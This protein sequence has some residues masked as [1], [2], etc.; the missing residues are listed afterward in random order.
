MCTVKKK[1]RSDSEPN[2][3][4]ELHFVVFDGCCANYH[5]GR[6]IFAFCSVDVVKNTTVEW[7]FLLL[8]RVTQSR[9]LFYKSLW[10]MNLRRSIMVW[11]VFEPRSFVF[12][13]QAS[14]FHRHCRQKTIKSVSCTPLSTK[15]FFF[16]YRCGW[17][18]STLNY[19]HNYICM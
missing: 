17:Y 4:S 3:R 16:V 7:Y 6:S 9:R 2:S 12:E 8:Y 15:C 14:F 5:C 10:A 1:F 18:F 11:F 13:L 19:I